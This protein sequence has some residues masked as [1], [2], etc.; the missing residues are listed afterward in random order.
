MTINRALI[1]LSGVIAAYREQ[2][3]HQLGTL[4]QRRFSAAPL[5]SFA[6]LASIFFHYTAAAQQ[7][8]GLWVSPNKRGSFRVPVIGLPGY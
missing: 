1:P 3:T 5:V 4:S 6:S 2:P 7:R 8:A